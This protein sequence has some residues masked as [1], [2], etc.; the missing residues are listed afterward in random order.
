MRSF[1]TELRR[2]NVYKA[3]AAYAVV[4]WLVVQIATQVLPLFDVSP[5][6]LR[7]IVLLIVAG[8]PIVLILSWVYEVTPEGIVN[9]RT[10]KSLL[11]GSL[12]TL[13]GL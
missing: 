7:V 5:L 3:G 6:A 13:N 4:G 12:P 9:P 8:F 2:R 1:F 10:R 11:F